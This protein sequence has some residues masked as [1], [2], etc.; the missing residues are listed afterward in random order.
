MG[1]SYL[2]PLR[3][4]I[5]HPLYQTLLVAAYARSVP[6][7]ALRAVAA[8]A[9]SVAD[10][11]RRQIAQPTSART[12]HLVAPPLPAPSGSI[13][14]EYATARIAPGSMLGDASARVA[15][16]AMTVPDTA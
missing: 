3:P 13:V 12:A 4:T 1:P 7:I 16:Q 5:H 15:A 11:A 8:W 2:I 6:G 14:S 9:M 10:I